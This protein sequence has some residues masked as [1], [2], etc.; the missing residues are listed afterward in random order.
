MSARL[1]FSMLPMSLSIWI[2]RAG[3]R[4]AQ[5]TASTTEA[6]VNVIKFL[7]A[8]FI[9]KA[10]GGKL[11]PGFSGTPIAHADHLWNFLGMVLA[12]LAFTLAGGCPGR[13]LVAAGEGS[14]D[15]GVFVVGSLVG[16][17]LAHNLALAAIPDK[18]DVIGGPGPFGQ[19]AVIVGILFCVAVGLFMRH[20]TA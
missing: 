16:A 5:H 8:A 9:V 15:A 3:L 10:I 2:E 14:T 17:A 11:W 20:R 18:G 13:Q 12:G 1:P 4:L 19:G 7:T 6:P